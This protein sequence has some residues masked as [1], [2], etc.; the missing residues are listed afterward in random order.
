VLQAERV[1]DL[2]HQGGLAV[3]AVEQVEVVGLVLVD[4]SV[5]LDLGVAA[6]AA[7]QERGE[8]AGLGRGAVGVRVHEDDVGAGAVLLHELDGH[9]VVPQADRGARRGPL[10][11]GERRE[12]A[13]QALEPFM[14]IVV[15]AAR[16]VIEEGVGDRAVAGDRPDGAVAIQRRGRLR[17]R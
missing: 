12:A 13:D 14:R 16:I 9:Q 6:T 8:G 15:E 2:V 1:P 4:E 3:A 17:G 7:V 11:L 5:A 10:G